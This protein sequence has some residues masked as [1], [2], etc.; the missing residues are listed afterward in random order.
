MND[1]FLC[2]HV[3]LVIGLPPTC[4]LMSFTLDLTLSILSLVTPS[5]LST[6]SHTFLSS[7]SSELRHRARLQVIA[8]CSDTQ[9]R[10]GVWGRAC[11]GSGH[12]E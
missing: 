10:G 9:K 1:A 4:S 7:P 6:F 11:V 5:P 3:L 2:Q 8:P 12:M